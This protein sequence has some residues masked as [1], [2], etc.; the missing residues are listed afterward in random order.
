M[1]TRWLWLAM[2]LLG[3]T[4]AGLADNYPFQGHAF[5][6][7]GTISQVDGNRDRVIFNGDNGHRY[8]LDTS[9]SDITLSNGKR[10]GVT[11]DLSPGM[12]IHVSGK[13]LS[14]SIAEVMQLRVLETPLTPRP[15]HP[16]VSQTVP[17]VPQGPD[18]PDAITLRGTVDTVNTQQGSFV[19]LVKDH[20]R[21]ILLADDTDLNGLGR[22]DP[23][24][25]PVKPGDRVTVAGKLQP[26]GDVLAGALSYSRTLAFPPSASSLPAGVLLGHIS[27]T[28]NRYTNRDIKIRLDDDRE[29]TIKVPHG[30]PIHREGASI[31][32][33]DLRSEDQVR[34][35]GS[36]DR[37]DF[38]A[39]RID[40]THPVE[41]TPSP[42]FSRL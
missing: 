7:N 9:D 23:G 34:V 8:T 22:I 4:T 16:E 3:W 20:S 29:V 15:K 40:V 11:P 26:N 12:R 41:V 36:Y 27:S 21:T 13:L 5:V 2:L 24:A 17:A 39:T 33:H 28:S 42:G 31:S 19:V 37:G 6:M 14:A 32:V 1:R 25:F 30:I 18:D 10:A 35:T 38:R